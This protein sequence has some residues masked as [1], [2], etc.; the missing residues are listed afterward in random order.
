MQAARHKRGTREEQGDVKGGGPHQRPPTAPA[1]TAAPP[2]RLPPLPLLP[3]LLQPLL[4][5]R[6][7]LPLLPRLLRPLPYLQGL[8]IPGWTAEGVDLWW[9]QLQKPG[10]GR[11]GQARG[12]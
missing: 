10:A 4:L 3:T 5:R 2:L 6:L 11:A 1:A 8:D 9:R 12:G 7:P